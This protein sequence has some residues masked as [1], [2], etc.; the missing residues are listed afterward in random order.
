MNNVQLIAW[1]PK[2]DPPHLAQ[3]STVLLSP[4]QPL[5]LDRSTYLTL[6]SNRVQQLVNRS[7]DPQESV[8]ALVDQMYE[9]ALLPDQGTVKWQ[10]AGPQL[11]LSNP[12]VD[13]RLRELA[14]YSGLKFAKPTEQ[15]LARQVVNDDLQSPQ[16]RLLDWASALATHR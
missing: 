1:A 7:L 8:N 3:I 12:T 16:S 9:D 4:K 5:P 13:L 14:I 6:L 15:E 2:S 11:V 10:A